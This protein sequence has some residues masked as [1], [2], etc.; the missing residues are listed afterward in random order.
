MATGQRAFT[1]DSKA[2]LIGSIM[3]EEPRPISELRPTSPPALDRL[4]KKC[5]QKDPED[6]W[7]TAKDLKDELE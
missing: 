5:L 2:S 4:I 6:R 1:G 7:Q 3:K